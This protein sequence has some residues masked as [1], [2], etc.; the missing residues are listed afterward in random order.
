MIAVFIIFLTH[1]LFTLYSHILILS[2]ILSCGKN[3]SNDPLGTK[4]KLIGRNAT[5]VV[6]EVA[7]SPI[8]W[9]TKTI[10]VSVGGAMGGT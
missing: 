5:G 1:S 7:D 9:R 2:C 6:I 3:K 10:G 8:G 4:A